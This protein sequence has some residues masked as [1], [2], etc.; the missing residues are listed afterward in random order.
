[1]TFVENCLVDVTRM[2]QFF[3]HKLNYH[4]TC[5]AV[6]IL[7]LCIQWVF[8]LWKCDVCIA[9]EVFLILH[10]M[11]NW[12]FTNNECTIRTQWFMGSLLLYYIETYLS[13]W[14]INQVHFFCRSIDSSLHEPRPQWLLWRLLQAQ[15]SQ[16]NSLTN[17]K[18]ACI[19]VDVVLINLLM[20]IKMRFNYS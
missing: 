20:I 7:M 6:D 13:S 4:N 15:F 14:N 2:I 11:Y 17:W 1:M 9:L 16:W 8:Y 18:H 5:S 3:H 10:S 12:L 19:W